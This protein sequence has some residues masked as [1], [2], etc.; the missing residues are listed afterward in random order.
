M[1]PRQHVCRAIEPDLL[2][3]AAD[4]AGFAAA[5]RV[6]AHV[7]SCQPCRDELACYRTLEDMI[8]SLR[9]APLADDDATSARARLATRLSDLR[10]RI[11]RRRKP[12]TSG[13]VFDAVS[14]VTWLRARVRRTYR[15]ATGR[16]GVRALIRQPSRLSSAEIIRRPNRGRA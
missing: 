9:C 14:H 11:P 8:D 2:S 6:E 7:G 13:R 16:A 3:V 4:E 15:P 12:R 5:G 1:S 10:S